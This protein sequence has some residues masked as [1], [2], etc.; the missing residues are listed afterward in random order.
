MVLRELPDDLVRKVRA[1]AVLD[2]ISLKAWVELKLTAALIV[3]A[4]LASVSVPALSS[5]DKP[6]PVRRN[7]ERHSTQSKA[8][9]T[10]RKL[11]EI[12]SPRRLRVK[13]TDTDSLRGCRLESGE[14]GIPVSDGSAEDGL[15]ADERPAGVHTTATSAVSDKTC[16]HGFKNCPKCGFKDGAKLRDRKC[17]N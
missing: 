9:K 7:V 16:A 11:T 13:G 2:G 15:S 6:A 8:R 3:S 5:K 1:Q 14:T 12:S 17:T 4:D 10:E